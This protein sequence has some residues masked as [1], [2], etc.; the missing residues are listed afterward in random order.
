MASIGSVDVFSRQIVDLM[1]IGSAGWQIDE[2]GHQ[3]PKVRLWGLPLISALATILI[4]ATVDPRGTGLDCVPCHPMSGKR[5]DENLR[6]FDLLYSP[7]QQQSLRDLDRRINE[8]EPTRQAEYLAALH[9]Y[10]NWLNLLPETKQEELKQTPPARTNGSG[11]EAFERP[12]CPQSSARLSSSVSSTW[13]KIRRSSWRR[14]TR[15]GRR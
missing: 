10:H 11:Q 15:S 7:D 8:I 14:S 4:A 3:A 1:V 6:R 13:E 12:S 9:R 2:F 5:L